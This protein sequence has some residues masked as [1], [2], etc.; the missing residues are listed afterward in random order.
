MLKSEVF[1]VKPSAMKVGRNFDTMGHVRTLVRHTEIARVQGKKSFKDSIQALEDAHP[2][3]DV[4]A[5]EEAV[6]YTVLKTEAGQFLKDRAEVKALQEEIATLR[7]LEDVTGLCVTD[8]THVYLMA[9]AIYKSVVLDADLFDPEK[10]GVDISA[11]IRNYYSKGGSL[12]ELKDSLRPVFNRII[13]QEGE[14]FYAVKT[15]KADFAEPD[16]RH[17]LAA[18]GGAAKRQTV[19]K[20]GVTNYTDFNYVDKSGNKKAQVAAFT[21]LCAVVLDNASKHSI[22]RPEATEAKAE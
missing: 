20:D 18:F 11:P 15:K 7:P 4:M 8:K 9:H 6:V 2:G 17:F 1:V 10:G 16:L 5:A 22:I 3:I 14:N 12:K 13:G 19:K 21:T